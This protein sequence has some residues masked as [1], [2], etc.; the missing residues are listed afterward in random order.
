MRASTA[1]QQL[2]D[3]AGLGPVER[4]QRG[5]ASF[6]QPVAFDQRHADGGVEFGQILAQ[7]RRA[8][9]RHANAPAQA[10]ANLREHDAV[11]EAQRDAASTGHR[12][13]ALAQPGWLPRPARR[14]RRTAGAPARGACGS[15][16]QMEE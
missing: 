14:P 8:R 5:D 7:R 1:G 9:S 2:A 6:G 10:L 3:A 16:P 4:I 15:P 13:A 12:L 11:E